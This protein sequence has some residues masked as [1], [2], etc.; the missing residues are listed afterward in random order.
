[1]QNSDLSDSNNKIKQYEDYI[2]L[3]KEENELLNNKVRLLQYELNSIKSTNLN[4]NNTGILAY[5]Y[6]NKN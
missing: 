4:I 3:L 6:K 1:M 2:R 5:C